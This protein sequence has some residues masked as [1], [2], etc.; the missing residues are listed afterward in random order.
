MQ[1]LDLSI[2]VDSW[3][4]IGLTVLQCSNWNRRTQ[5]GHICERVQM[6]WNWKAVVFLLICEMRRELPETSN[7]IHS[8]IFVMS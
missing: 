3:V 4:K 1:W 5:I 7:V 8:L 2:L 6:N